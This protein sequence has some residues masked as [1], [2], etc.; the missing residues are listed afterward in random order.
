MTEVNRK[1]MSCCCHPM[2][3]R[4]FPALIVRAC[5]TLLALVALNPNA[6]AREKLK[7]LL[8]GDSTTI[9]N[10]LRAV[11]PAGPHLEQ[12]IEQL[13]VVE[14][15]PALEVINAGKGGETAQRLLGSVWYEQAIAHVAD[16][17][18][19]FVR[20]GIN[21]WFKCKDLKGEFPRQLRAVIAQL[22]QD[23]PKA[24]IIP[25]TICRFM[26][27]P[28]CVEV[29]AL[30]KEVAQAESLPLFDLYTPYD[31]FLREEGENTLNVREC[32][33]AIIPGNYHAW[34]KP[35]T[36]FQKGWGGRPDEFVVKVNDQSLDPIFG[37]IQGWYSNRHPN[38]T[39]Y[40]LI[41]AETVKFLK[42]L[43]RDGTSKG[44]QP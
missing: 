9:G 40:N 32:P 30:I 11:N 33:L 8:V 42:P 27:P 41:A 2:K 6:G 23:H 28:A 37:H 4:R 35:H 21:D 24:R 44:N 26:P 39:G 14:G 36:V 5:A 1:Y 13:A 7:V 38:S 22:R 25:S 16:V 15:L 29:N 12:M 10:T 20:L 19:I 18:F 43:L 17:D 34:L 31:Q 3:A